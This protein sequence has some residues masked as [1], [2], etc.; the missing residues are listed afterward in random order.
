M[1]LGYMNLYAESKWFPSNKAVTGVS[2]LYYFRQFVCSFC[3][4]FDDCLGGSLF[5]ITGTSSDNIIVTHYQPPL[6]YTII[7]FKY[8]TSK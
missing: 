8:Y 1:H 6:L 3:L 5:I 4:I 2:L 7:V